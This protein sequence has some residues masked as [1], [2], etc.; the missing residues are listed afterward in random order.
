MEINSER[1]VDKMPLMFLILQTEEE[2]TDL[3]ES[4]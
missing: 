4:H 3:T 1:A 2:H